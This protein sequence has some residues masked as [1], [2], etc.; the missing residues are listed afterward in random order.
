L[1]ICVCTPLRSVAAAAFGACSAR[2]VSLRRLLL[3]GL[4]EG[5][6]AEWALFFADLDV[7]ALG[8]DCLGVDD[9]NFRVADLMGPSDFL[10]SRGFF[11]GRVLAESVPGFFV[12]WTSDD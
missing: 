4:R 9:A 6:V 10:A 7:V 11:E 1:V 3:R 5:F 12:G 8:A 2:A